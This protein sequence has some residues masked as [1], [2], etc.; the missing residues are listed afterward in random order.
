MRILHIN[1]NYMLTPLHQTM[2]EELERK[3]IENIV[4]APISKDT[5]IT[6]TLNDNVCAS[7]CFNKWDR[8]SFFHK[9]HKIIKAIEKTCD[10]SSFDL[11][12]AYTL[13][14]DGNVA[15]YISRKYRIPYVVAVR[16]TDVNVFFKY[17]FY[18]RK[19]GQSIMCHAQQVFFLSQPYKDNVLCSYVSKSRKA[20]L[21]EKARVIPNGIDSFWLENKYTD[22]NYTGLLEKMKNKQ[23]S[24]IFAGRIDKNKNIQTTCR[25]IQLLSD[26]GW[27]IHFFVIG[28]PQDISVVTTLKKFSFCEVIPPK[29]KEELIAFYRNADIFVM[30]SHTETFGLAYAEAMT[31][32]LPVIYSKGQGFDGQFDDGEVGFS[33]KSDSEEN[34]ANSIVKICKQYNRISDRCI[35]LCEKFSWASIA[36]EYISIY[37]TICFSFAQNDCLP[38]VK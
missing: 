4:F 31:Q 5:R 8:I 21:S 1:C 33:V 30:P 28:K 6:M 10:I 37:Q 17:R 19:L 34:V 20:S 22:R 27:K 14:T 38:H 29:R 3:G 16:N 35:M 32:G 18:L 15:R 26:K 9:Q 2:V 25:A 12:H 24:V 11:I 7:K 36:T 23:L 13:F